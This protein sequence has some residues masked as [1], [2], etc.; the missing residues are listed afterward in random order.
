MQNNAQKYY[1]FEPLN[2]RILIKPDKKLEETI[3][4]SGIVLAD[5]DKDES[6]TGVVVNGDKYL[7]KGV[8]VL[9]SKFGYDEV[10]IDKEIFY[11]VSISNILGKFND[12]KL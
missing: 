8:R 2:N 1:M 4:N 10:E 5:K 9:F 6:L 12:N 11:V 3:T 7:S